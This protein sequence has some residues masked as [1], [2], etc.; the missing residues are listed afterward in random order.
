[1]IAQLTGEVA[2][3]DG[4]GIVLDVH[5]VGYYIHLVKDYEQKLGLGV[6]ISILTYLAVRENALNLYGFQNTETLDYF[7]LLLTV[8][9]I[10]PK[11][12]LA[13]LSL[14]A[15]DVLRRA[16]LADDTTYLTR[17]SGIG[18]KNAEKIIVTLKDKL[19]QLETGESSLLA[20]EVET[21][22]TLQA[23]GYTLAEARKALKHIP[24]TAKDTGE[25]VKAALKILG[26]HHQH[27]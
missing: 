9:G 3:K 17:I 6:K 23:L 26:S 25:K 20:D 10:G 18:R 14:A 1:M 11:S 4:R 16:I 5:G 2:R 24:S 8:P 13:I 22:E 19:G 12:A 21:L 15:P 7:E 27:S